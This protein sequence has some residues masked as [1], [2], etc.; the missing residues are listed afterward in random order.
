MTLSIL[1]V[2]PSEH[3]IPLRQISAAEEETPLVRS[4]PEAAQAHVWASLHQPDVVIVDSSYLGHGTA[5]FILRFRGN[6]ACSAIPV[7]TI[8]DDVDRNGALMAGANALVAAPLDPQR[9]RALV[10][11]VLHGDKQRWRHTDPRRL[12]E[13]PYNTP[14]NGHAQEYDVLSRLLHTEKFC[15]KDTGEHVKR[16]GNISRRIAEALGR[17]AQ[18]CHVIEV[19][20]ALHDIGKIG[21]P[22]AILHKPGPLTYD[23]RR[24]MKT[25]TRIGFDILKSSRSAYLQCAALMAL[26]HHE[27]FDGMGYP[28]NARGEEIPL[29]ARIVAVADVYDA[30]SSRRSYKLGWTA[31]KTLEHLTEQKGKHFDPRCVEA[32]ASQV[33]PIARAP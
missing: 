22:D 11:S 29:C 12:G 26:S 32:L 23:E 28:N 1:N 15:D 30:L 5:D 4:L 20:A 18:E 21:I 13:G 17:P 16:V 9:C 8:A 2:G 31:E 27:R 33:Q 14:R 19:A 10:L 25:H 3:E 24:I 6:P 7:L